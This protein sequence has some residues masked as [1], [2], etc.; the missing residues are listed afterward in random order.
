M[1]MTRSRVLVLSLVSFLLTVYCPV[2]TQ[3]QRSATQTAPPIDIIRLVVVRQGR[4]D[5]EMAVRRQLEEVGFRTTLPTATKYDVTL[6]VDYEETPCGEYVPVGKGTCISCKVAL[7]HPREGAL[8][9]DNFTAST[10]FVVQGMD[11]WSSAVRRFEDYSGF[12]LLGL[13]V[14]QKAQRRLPARYLDSVRPKL[15]HHSWEI[16]FR[17]VQALPAIQDSRWV[18]ETTS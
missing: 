3:A 6:N 8:L 14:A 2:P 12:A 10:E 17:A 18:I 9:E 5:I 7:L 4:Y 15:Q 11:L 13:N 1:F 16:R